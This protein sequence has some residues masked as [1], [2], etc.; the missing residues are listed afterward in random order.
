MHNCY[1]SP[2]GEDPFDMIDLLEKEFAISKM[3]PFQHLQ[4][5][6]KLPSEYAKE[7]TD[8]MIWKVKN[9]T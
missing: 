7:Y 9:L 5:I 6:Q 3:Y 1:V 4:L 2:Y 8:R